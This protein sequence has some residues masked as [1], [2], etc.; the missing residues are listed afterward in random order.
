L[1]FYFTALFDEVAERFEEE[2]NNHQRIG[3]LSPS[4]VHLEA[5]KALNQLLFLRFPQLNLFF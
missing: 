2:S 4:K 3:F 1:I 5:I